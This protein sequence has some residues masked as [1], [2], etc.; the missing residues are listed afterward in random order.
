MSSTILSPTVG[1]PD[2]FPTTFFIILEKGQREK[3]RKNNLLQGVILNFNRQMNIQESLPGEWH[4]PSPSTAHLNSAHRQD[5]SGAQAS[6]LVKSKWCPDTTVE[7]QENT[8]LSL[9]P[10]TSSR[11]ILDQLL[12]LRIFPY[13]QTSKQN[14]HK[15]RLY[16]DLSGFLVVK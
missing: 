3:K 8:G 1:Q 2:R 5:P 4:G 7:A 11:E 16:S 9:S 14:H 13:S 15:T 6:T 10:P 12:N